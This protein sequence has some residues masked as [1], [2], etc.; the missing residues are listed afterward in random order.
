M[1]NHYPSPIFSIRVPIPETHFPYSDSLVNI[2]HDSAP[3]DPA[4]PSSTDPFNHVSKYFI[5]TIYTGP[6]FHA[7]VNIHPR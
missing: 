7:V 5:I 3:S 1:A 2:L 4:Y 6:T